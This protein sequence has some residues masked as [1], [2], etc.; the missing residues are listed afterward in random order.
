MVKIFHFAGV[1][2]NTLISSGFHLRND[3]SGG[4]GQ[5]KGGEGVVRVMLFRESV[6]VSL[7]TERRVLEPR[8]LKGGKNAKSGENILLR[9]NGSKLYLGPKT[10][11]EVMPGERLVLK[12]PG[13]GGY[14]TPGEKTFNDMEGQRKKEMKYMK[15][16][17]GSVEQYKLIQ[18]SA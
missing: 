12:T 18:E 16:S 8:G 13:G 1:L 11:V 9:C 15:P 6:T 17:F 4:E 14:G 5:Y 10:S 7:L 2:L 3:N